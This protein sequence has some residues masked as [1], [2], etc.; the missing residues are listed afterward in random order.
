M[1]RFAR[2]LDRTAIA[3]LVLWIALVGAVVGTW[4]AWRLKT[5]NAPTPN[6]QGPV[7]ALGDLLEELRKTSRAMAESM[8]RRSAELKTLVSEADGRI[9]VLTAAPRVW[10][11]KVLDYLGVLSSVEG[12]LFTGDFIFTNNKD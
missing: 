12:N 1:S 9:A 3:G 10:A 5:P 11:S 7:R 6:P 2:H 8:D 4:L